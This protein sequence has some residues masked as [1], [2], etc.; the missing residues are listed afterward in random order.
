[1]SAF[2]NV[3]VIRLGGEI[4]CRRVGRDGWTARASEKY[5][6][7]VRQKFMLEYR[8]EEGIRGLMLGD[9]LGTSMGDI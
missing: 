5:Q 3:L 6:L 8:P 1:M 4:K 2:Q 9:I 7:G